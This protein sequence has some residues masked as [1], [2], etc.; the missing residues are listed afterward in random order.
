MKNYKQTLFLGLAVLS[1]SI[2][3]ACSDD[4]ETEVCP[5][6]IAYPT[7]LAFSDFEQLSFRMWTNGKEVN[8]S[9]LDFNDYLDESAAVRF[10]A[11][12]F[13]YY[14]Y[15]FTPDSIF[16]VVD[17]N[18][19]EGV[20][21]FTSNDSIIAILPE[22]LNEENDLEFFFGEGSPVSVRQTTSYVHQCDVDDDGDLLICYYHEGNEWQTIESIS[23][24]DEVLFE[25]LDDIQL[26]D[27][28]IIVNQYVNFN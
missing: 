9:D 11:D 12:E 28:L 27:T 24:L 4:D 1:M 20:P 7:S 22:D 2:F 26:G 15:T 3:S 23:E 5:P 18:N 25:S 13:N 6:G 10:T 19:I 8:T 16:Y 14:T 21:Y 17:G